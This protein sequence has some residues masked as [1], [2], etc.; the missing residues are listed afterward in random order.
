MAC[1]VRQ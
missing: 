1:T